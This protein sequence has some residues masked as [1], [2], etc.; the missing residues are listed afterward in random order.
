MTRTSTLL[1]PAWRLA[2]LGLAVLCLA[3]PALAQEGSRF[4]LYSWEGSRGDYRYVV[5]PE[6]TPTLT[7]A[8]VTAASHDVVGIVAELEKL[9]RGAT[10]TWLTRKQLEARWGAAARPFGQALPRAQ[11]RVRAACARTGVTLLGLGS[12][13]S[14]I[15]FIGDGMGVSQ[16]TLGRMGAAAAKQPYH[17]DRFKSLGLSSTRSASHPVT[18]SAA[19]ATALA[20]GIK[21]YNKAIGV[22][23]EKRPVRTILEAAHDA[24]YVT[25]L[26]TTTRITHAT[27]A[28]F[29]AKVDHRSKEKEIA[30]QMA[31]KGYPE[32][33]IGGGARNFDDLLLQRFRGQG[34]EVIT[35]RQQLAAA[36]GGKIVA[37][38]AGSHVPY[39]VDEGPVLE[40]LTAKAVEL[41]SAQGPFFLMVEGGRVDH[42]GHQHDAVS[43]LTEQL[44]LDRAVG[45]ALD[46]AQRDRDLLVVLTADH[47]TGNL[48]ITENAKFGEMLRAKASS[49][50]LAKETKPKPGE[51]AALAKAVKETHGF[52]LSAEELAFVTKHPK[53]GYWAGT[54]LGHVLSHR[55]G[56]EFY[57]ADHQQQAL[58]NTHGHD[59][60]MVPVFAYGPGAETFQGIYENT[61]IPKKIAAI[62]GLTGT[63]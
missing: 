30:Q 62:L 28:C 57:D 56:I 12:R 7:H 15:Y 39:V 43:V 58:T 20:A 32:V 26:V 59:G 44:D 52:E 40:S 50:Q 19:G 16:V 41:L 13:R 49:T 6:Q 18:D 51:T 25:G 35:E 8:K 53:D 33:L 37:L 22:D 24:G 4:E 1:G 45:W 5:L 47:A 54:A 60:G 38:I 34:F 17:L 10:L 36:K 11:M 27:P 29:V 2:L 48:G 23:T 42:G 9:P 14:V 55:Y 63:Q 31:A 3:T 21:T 46:R 61:E